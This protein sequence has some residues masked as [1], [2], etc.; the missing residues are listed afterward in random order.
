[1]KY[2]PTLN[3][4]PRSIQSRYVSGAPRQR[5]NREQQKSVSLKLIHEKKILATSKMIICGV[6]QFLG[7]NIPFPDFCK[8]MPLGVNLTRHPK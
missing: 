1:M 7:P 2:L 5:F 8:S 6:G 3:A 4:R